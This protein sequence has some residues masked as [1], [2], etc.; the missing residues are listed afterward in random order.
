MY[1]ETRVCLTTMLSPNDDYHG[2]TEVFLLLIRVFFFLF[3]LLCL[4]LASSFSRRIIRIHVGNL[5][6]GHVVSGD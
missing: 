4:F 2:L 3:V 1:D 6:Y 5:Q